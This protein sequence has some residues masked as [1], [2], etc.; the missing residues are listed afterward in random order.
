MNDCS[1]LRKQI[2]RYLEANFVFCEL[3]TGTVNI[4]GCSSGFTGFLVIKGTW[5]RLVSGLY[6]RMTGFD[7]GSP[8]WGIFLLMNWQR[9]KF[10]S[11]YQSLSLSLLLHQ[12]SIIIHSL[13]SD[14]I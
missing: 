1:F 6:P 9:D 10:T 4:T 8:T 7:P 12:C 13:I 11:E 14:P 5:N 3:K 2:I